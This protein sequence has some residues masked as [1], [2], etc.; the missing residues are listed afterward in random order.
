MGQ[1]RQLGHTLRYSKDA[2]T[3]G[4]IFRVTNL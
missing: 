1:L 4:V 3:G 2:V